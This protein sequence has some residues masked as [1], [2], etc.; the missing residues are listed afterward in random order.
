VW[1]RDGSAAALPRYRETIG[2]VRG[3]HRPVELA[4]VLVGLGR[5]ELAA[6]ERDAG[7]AHLNEAIALYQRMGSAL[8]VAETGALLSFLTSSLSGA[9]PAAR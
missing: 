2:F 3:A 7:A 5:C 9:D 8:D 1:A 6:G 4:A